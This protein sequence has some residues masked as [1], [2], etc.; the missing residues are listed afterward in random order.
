MAVP[1]AFNELRH[2]GAGFMLVKVL[3]LNHR[4]GFIPSA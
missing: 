3:E 2:W 1:L 4:P